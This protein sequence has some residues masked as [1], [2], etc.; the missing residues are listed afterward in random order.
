MGM[1][2]WEVEISECHTV[3]VWI[4]VSMLPGTKV[5]PRST[6]FSL[7][8]YLENHQNEERQMTTMNYSLIGASSACQIDWNLICWIKVEK[9]VRRLQM[10]IAKAVRE[11]RHGKAKALQWLLSHSFSAKLIAVR[12]VTQN[13]GSK[14]AGVDK[15]VWTTPKHKMQAAE[16]IKRRGYQP[17]HSGDFIFPKR[18][19]NCVRY[20][21]QPW[22]TGYSKHFTC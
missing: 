12:R 9:Q 18:M 6:G 17:L 1:Q 10:R 15:V 8:D 4:R 21:F 19:G 14:T 13:K 2:V 11:E 22:L 3:I 7:Q 20:Q 5:G 16:N